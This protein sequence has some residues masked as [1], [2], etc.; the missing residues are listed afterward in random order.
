[1]FSLL[2][3]RG[4]GAVKVWYDAVEESKACRVVCSGELKWKTKAKTD[5]WPWIDLAA[6]LGEIA[7]AWRKV[8]V[9]RGISADS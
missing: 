2:R 4:E 6:V 3:N 1:M 5:W 8:S 9:L 7:V